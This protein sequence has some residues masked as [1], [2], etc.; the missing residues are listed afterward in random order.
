RALILQH[1]PVVGHAVQGELLSD[2]RADLRRARRH[3]VDERPSAVTLSCSLERPD[4]LGHARHLDLVLGALERRAQER[5]QRVELAP[6]VGLVEVPAAE[7]R[8]GGRGRRRPRTSAPEPHRA[9]SASAISRGTWSRTALAATL[10]A[11][12]MA[13]ALERAWHLMKSC[14]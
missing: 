9:A 11:L 14:S 6:E 7:E 3:E 2:R 12:P 4:E 13:R 10:T 5:A 1:D 8:R